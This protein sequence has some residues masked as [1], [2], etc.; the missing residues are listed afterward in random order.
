MI[1]NFF[2]KNLN[3]SQHLDVINFMIVDEAEMQWNYHKECNFSKDGFR[4]ASW[5][6][7]VIK[8][9]VNQ[10]FKMDISN[11][12]LS[13]V[14]DLGFRRG[15]EI[16]DEYWQL[17]EEVNKLVNEKI[18]DKL[19]L[20]NNSIR[21]YAKKNLDMEYVNERIHLNGIQFVDFQRKKSYLETVAQLNRYIFMYVNL[22]V[23]RFKNNNK[24]IDKFISEREKSFNTLD[25][26]IKNKKIK[27]F[28]KEVNTLINKRN[29]NNLLRYK[30]S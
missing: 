21:L 28:E 14:V 29:P 1:F 7:N 20:A 16:I 3:T 19:F 26:K 13:Y 30:D 15:K 24:L 4:S 12:I 23:T 6:K 18:S 17:K 10:I 25:E 8:T 5:S 9:M 2:K 11:E 27:D 22:L